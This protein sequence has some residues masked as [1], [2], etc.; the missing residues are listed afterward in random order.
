MVDKEQVFDALDGVIDPELR[1]SL[2]ELGMVHDV[3]ID[4]G[5]I[6]LTLALTTLAC[7]LREQIM[8]DARQA[9]LALDSVE[10][11]DL[12]LREMTQEEKERIWPKQQEQKR[13]AAAELNDIRYVIAVM[14]GKG[15]VG[16]SSVAAM[17]ATALRRQGKRVGVLD[18]DITGPS[19][20]K[21]FGLHDPPPM[22]P[23]GILPAETS[24]GI[25][26]MSINL[27][28]PREDE[29]VIWRGPLIS[30][31]IQQFWGDVVWGNLDAL[32]VDLPPGTSDASLT[33]M[34]AMPLSGVLLV[35]SPQELAGMVVRKAARMAEHLDI[36]ILGLVENMSFAV[37]PECGEQIEVFGPSQAG[38]VAEQLGIPLLG[39]LPLDP[40]LA[41]KCDAGQVEAYESLQF[42]AMADLVW[43]RLPEEKST[44]VFAQ[45]G[46]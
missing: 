16:K 6:S 4:D 22:G 26:V 33:V 7:P 27:L 10:E 31:A 44:P 1:K 28:L 46:A 9:L 19:I 39:Q 18:A 45:Q 37:C 8:D 41:R 42:N 21:M 3:E 2:V 36:P 20:P 15:G 14:S 23:M 17:L 34:Q 24:S 30:G 32:V 13:G 25:R 12:T 43:E 38:A 11:V 35:T 5:T 40:E 29:A